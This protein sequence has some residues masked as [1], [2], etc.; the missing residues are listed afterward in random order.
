MSSLFFLNVGITVPSYFCLFAAFNLVRLQPN[1][2]VAAGTSMFVGFLRMNRIF[3]MIIR[4]VNDCS[5]ATELYATERI[6]TE[7]NLADSVS[8]RC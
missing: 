2:L 7:P 6:I 8:E 4:C 3:V 5:V 1:E